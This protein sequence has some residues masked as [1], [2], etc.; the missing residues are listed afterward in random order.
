MI[1]SGLKGKFGQLISSNIISKQSCFDLVC[2]PALKPLA[3]FNPASGTLET[4]LAEC[5]STLQS[6]DPCTRNASCVWFS[7]DVQNPPSATTGVLLAVSTANGIDTPS[8][9]FP[10][11]VLTSGD[12]GNISSFSVQESAKMA[13]K[14][15]LLSFSVLL[16]VRP[17]ANSSFSIFGL[18]G[19]LT[20]SGILVVTLLYE[21]NTEQILSGHWDQGTGTIS[22]ILTMDVP[23]Y[24]SVLRPCT[25]G[26][27][28]S[29]QVQLLNPTSSGSPV[30]PGLKASVCIMPECNLKSMIMPAFSATEIFSSVIPCNLTTDLCGVCGGDNSICQGCDGVPNSHNQLD[31]CGVCGGHNL[32]VGCDGV[33]NSGKRLDTCGVCGGSGSE[34]NTTSAGQIIWPNVRANFSISGLNQT[35]L[36]SSN[37][38]ILIRRAF[39]YTFGIVVNSVDILQLVSVQANRRIKGNLFFAFEVIICRKFK[40]SN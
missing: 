24:C 40:A 30:Q 15:N 10:N 16:N 32:C 26:H 5:I 38:N 17:L 7:F 28:F 2:Y 13:G 37:Q 18:V 36:S 1:L 9:S 8:T 4:T 25:L 23:E 27:S 11:L 35:N 39:A 21:D 19:S 31:M 3:D 33:V 12:L 20:R 14:L 22:F 34:C 29:M 6:D